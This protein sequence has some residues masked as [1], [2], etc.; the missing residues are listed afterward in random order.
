LLCTQQLPIFALQL[1]NCV[2]RNTFALC[3]PNFKPQSNSYSILERSRQTT[4]GLRLWGEEKQTDHHP[5]MR[6]Y[7]LESVYRGHGLSKR[8]TVCHANDR[9]AT[10]GVPWC[11]C[12][13]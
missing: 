6:D 3:A 7:P 2:V 5:V 9:T 4:E 1:L 10:D 12:V 13:G 11:W 8:F